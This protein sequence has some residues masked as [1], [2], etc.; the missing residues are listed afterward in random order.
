MWHL[1]RILALRR[2]KWGNCQFK[3]SL[4]YRKTTSEGWGKSLGRLGQLPEIYDNR[5]SVYVELD[6]SLCGGKP[7]CSHHPSLLQC[8][9]SCIQFKAFLLILVKTVGNL[10]HYS[11][12]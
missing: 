9:E 3:A 11:W 12:P 1:P 2:W 4:S 5:Q 10:S 6:A 7:V 8:L